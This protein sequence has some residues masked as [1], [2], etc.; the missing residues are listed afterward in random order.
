MDRLNVRPTCSTHHTTLENQD[1]V[2]FKDYRKNPIE[3]L[4]CINEGLS[5]MKEN[6]W[7][8]TKTLLDDG[9]K[10]ITDNW[11]SAVRNEINTYEEF[12]RAFRSK[13]WSE[14]IQN[15]SLIHI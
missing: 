6:R 9:F 15:L 12:K 10:G 11:W 5:R 3:F 14:S 8:T 7:S 1:S 2:S 13:N 4:E